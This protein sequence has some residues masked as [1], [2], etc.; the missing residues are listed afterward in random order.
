MAL[1]STQPLTEMSTRNV[2]GS[3]VRR[4]RKADNLTAICEPTVSRENV[5]ASKSH[6]L[7][8]LHGLF[9]GQIYLFLTIWGHPNL[10][11][12]FITISTGNMPVSRNWEKGQTLQPLITGAW[13]SVVM[14]LKKYA[15]FS[16][17]FL[18]ERETKT[19]WPCEALHSKA[20]CSGPLKRET[21]NF[22][23]RRIIKILS[24]LRT[25]YCLNVKS[26]NIKK[27]CG[28]VRQI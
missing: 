19:W 10:E 18:V 9:Q 27:L 14:E 25:K 3:R 4:A 5:G 17:V 12:F 21:G 1:G 13:N 16:S 26:Y 23:W 28:Y 20:P 15:T 7:M 6:N 8:G 22:V 24:K 2:P 11:R